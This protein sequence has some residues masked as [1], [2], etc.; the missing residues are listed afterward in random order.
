MKIES[1]V[2][3]SF[4]RETAKPA[5]KH[6]FIVP[7]ATVP[8][9]PTDAIDHGGKKSAPPGLERALARLQ[10][11]PEVDR[12]AGHT[13]AI[14]KLSRNLARYAETEALAAPPQTTTPATDST[15]SSEPLVA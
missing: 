14:E 10:T 1:G 9:K 5:S 6:A 7:Q 11:A 2:P 12:N 4:A 15:V 13:N 3:L 8:S